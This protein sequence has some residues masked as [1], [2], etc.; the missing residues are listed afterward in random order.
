MVHLRVKDFGR[1]L[2]TY[3]CSQKQKLDIHIKKLE[4]RMSE[5]GRYKLSVSKKMKNYL[6]KE[7]YNEEFGARPVIR[8]ITKYIQNPASKAVLKGDVKEGD[9]I[10]IDYNEKNDE[11]IVNKKNNL[12][13]TK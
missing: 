8:A 5:R 4:K 9:T 2:C 12:K 10:F 11:I 7:S 3:N 6:L 1:K 13:K